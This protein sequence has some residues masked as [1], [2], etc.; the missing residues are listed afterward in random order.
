MTTAA[1]ANEKAQ[2]KSNPKELAKILDSYATRAAVLA[3]QP[4]AGDDVD[5]NQLLKSAESL[6]AELRESAERD[7]TP[8]LQR[9]PGD[10]ADWV[11]IIDSAAERTRLVSTSP[12][13]RIPAPVPAAKEALKPAIEKGRAA[14]RRTAQV[15]EGFKLEPE[16]MEALRK[17]VFADRPP[18]SG[19]A[20]WKTELKT[21][22]SAIRTL[23]KSCPPALE[24]VLPHV[25]AAI[26]AVEGAKPAPGGR[27]PA[28]VWS[29]AVVESSLALALVL[30]EVLAWAAAHADDARNAAILRILA[31]KRRGDASREAAPPKPAEPAIDAPKPAE[32]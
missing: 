17:H 19:Q 18:A 5:P 9:H 26:T 7:A 2:P 24:A 20:G 27:P 1:K 13:A 22:A 32:A 30:G 4:D 8:K 28:P 6:T 11:E 31:P 21:I 12:G 29:P 25:E 23:E 14:V 16:V 3:A 10:A 15:I